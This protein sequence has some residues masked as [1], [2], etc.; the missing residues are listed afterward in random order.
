MHTTHGG[1]LVLPLSKT[2]L[3]TLADQIDLPPPPHADRERT[4]RTCVLPSPWALSAPSLS[5]RYIRCS[6]LLSLFGV[7]KRCKA[8]LNRLC[9]SAD[10]IAFLESVNPAEVRPQVDVFLSCS[11]WCYVA[12]M[13]TCRAFCMC[14]VVCARPNGYGDPSSWFVF[15]CLSLSAA[16]GLRG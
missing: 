5:R 15:L 9:C 10:V 2:I 7:C 8:L 3:G 6:P 13:Q 11:C 1:L 16:R 14:F 12:L 4:T